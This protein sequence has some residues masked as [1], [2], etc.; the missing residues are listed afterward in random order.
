M[1]QL[2]AQFGAFKISHFVHTSHRVTFDTGGR[3]YLIGIYLGL[4]LAVITTFFSVNV[5]ISLS[6]KIAPDSPIYSWQ[7]ALSMSTIIYSSVA[8]F[9]SVISSLAAI[10]LYMCV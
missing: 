6:A 9:V 10:C 8:S 2:I 1:K 7:L 4:L 3:L 5:Y